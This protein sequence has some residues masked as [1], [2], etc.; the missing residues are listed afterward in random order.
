MTFKALELIAED[1]V[2]LDFNKFKYSQLN[3]F[4]L[5]ISGLPLL[6]V[7]NYLKDLSDLHP[8]L[9]R[10][11]DLS[12]LTDRLNNIRDKCYDILLSNAKY[13]DKQYACAERDNIR[14]VLRLIGHNEPVKDISYTSY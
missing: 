6:S 2:I 7:R 3:E 12:E 14:Q 10:C 13:S 5:N 4:D 11:A 9:A 8:N 1:A